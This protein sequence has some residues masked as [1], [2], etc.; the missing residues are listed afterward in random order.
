MVKQ[1]L[2]VSFSGENYYVFWA[3]DES[4]NKVVVASIILGE[5]RDGKIKQIFEKSKA[6]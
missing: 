3:F 6:S 1:L 4:T 5:G 2:R